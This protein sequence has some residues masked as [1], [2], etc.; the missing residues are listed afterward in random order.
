M[1]LRF[2]ELCKVNA[3]FF[4][5]NRSLSVKGLM[6][7]FPILLIRDRTTCNRD[8]WWQ[9]PLLFWVH[10]PSSCLSAPYLSWHSVALAMKSRGQPGTVMLSSAESFAHTRT[11]VWRKTGGVLVLLSGFICNLHEGAELKAKQCEHWRT[12]AAEILRGQKGPN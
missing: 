4:R 10:C 9:V 3:A 7:D 5:S 1:A 8:L 2:R 6:L 12:S 11:T